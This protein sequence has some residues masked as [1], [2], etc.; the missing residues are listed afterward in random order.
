MLKMAICFVSSLQP[1]LSISPPTSTTYGEAY[2]TYGEAYSFGKASD[3]TLGFPPP[4]AALVVETPRNISIERSIIEVSS[5]KFHSAAVG[6]SGELYVWGNGKFGQLGTLDDSS[7]T[8]NKV[9]VP[10]KLLGTL[11]DSS[12]TKNKVKV[13]VK[14]LLYPTRVLNSLRYKTI[15]HVSCGHKHTLCLDA[16]GQTYG[17]GS[18]EFG[19]LGFEDP[20]A[21]TLT[22]RKVS[23]K[24]SNLKQKV[25]MIS[26]APFHSIVVGDSNSIFCFG[27]NDHAQCG[28]RTIITKSV[29]IP[30]VSE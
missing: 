28:V 21:E 23:V 11:D 25:K 30:V 7:P 8:K 3:F 6:I 20:T 2:T 29:F 10:V 16:T 22:P 4:K 12:P 13:P 19:Q 17:F 5:G 26:A 9:K 14:L 27:S 15:R 18:N 24:T 1:P